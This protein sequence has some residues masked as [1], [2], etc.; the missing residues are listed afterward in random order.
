MSEDVKHFDKG[1]IEAFSD[2]VFAIAITLLVLEVTIEPVQYDHLNLS[3]LLGR[4]P[5][6]RR[7]S[8]LGCSS[9]LGRRSLRGR[10]LALFSSLGDIHRTHAHHTYRTNAHQSDSSGE[11]YDG[12]FH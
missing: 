9:L 10:S 8:L 2:G 5:L 4:C 12:L 11:P 3:S 6:L 1:R 7:R